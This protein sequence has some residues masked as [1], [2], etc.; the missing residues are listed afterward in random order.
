[1]FVLNT[2][3]V[4]PFICHRWSGNKGDFISDKGTMTTREGVTYKG[5]KKVPDTQIQLVQDDE[6]IHTHNSIIVNVRGKREY[7]NLKHGIRHTFIPGTGGWYLAP[8][9]DY[10][11]TALEDNCLIDCYY[12]NDR[13]P[14]RWAR[15]VNISQPGEELVVPA[16][17]RHQFL[18]ICLGKVTIDDKVFEGTEDSPISIKI[19][20]GNKRKLIVSAPDTVWLRAWPERDNGKNIND[21][22]I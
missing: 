11:D 8:D 16:K 19:L 17:D 7:N 15:V 12:P 6:L 4:G 1:M 9:G 10:T 3:R 2:K 5:D 13:Y 20:P 18:I 14:R 22:D 21:L